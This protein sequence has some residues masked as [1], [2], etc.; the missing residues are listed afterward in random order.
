MISTPESLQACAMCQ[1]WVQ[2]DNECRCQLQAR[3]LTLSVGWVGSGRGRWQWS[4]PPLKRK[5]DMEIGRETGGQGEW[6]FQ[7]IK[8]LS[9]S[10]DAFG[11]ADQHH[12]PGEKEPKCEIHPDFIIIWWPIFYPR[13]NSII[14]STEQGHVWSRFNLI[15][16]RFPGRRIVEGLISRTARSQYCSWFSQK[17]GHSI[18]YTSIKSGLPH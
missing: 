7:W 9:T 11:Q 17:N 2:K 3:W 8:D 18:L 1:H 13:G 14:Q 4:K 5:L 6:T 16:P 15:W 10:S 12:H